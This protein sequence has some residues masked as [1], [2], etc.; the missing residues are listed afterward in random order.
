MY[1]VPPTTSRLTVKRAGKAITRHVPK[2]TVLIDTRER[3]PY[4][5]NYP[6]WLA[7]TAST[8]LKTGDYSI[9]GYEDRIS[10]ER[11]TLQDMVGSLMQGRERFLREMDRLS[12]F[13]HKCVLIEATRGQ[14]KTPYH[15]AEQVQAHPNGII[16]SL[17]AIATKYG[18]QI[19]Y[20]DNRELSEEF[21]ASWLSK[22]FTY[23]WL[24]DNGHGRYLQDGDL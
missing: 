16:G 2:P 5:L 12:L 19:V 13:R 11:K 18:I 24:E 7:G 20:G 10:L 3:L 23:E 22:A 4:Q 21:A 14:V 1:P 17:D 9:A 8:A 15:F 6:N